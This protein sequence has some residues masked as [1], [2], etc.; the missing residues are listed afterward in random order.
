[1]RTVDRNSQHE[2]IDSEGTWAI[3]YG[4]MVTLLL[5][6]FIL[7]FTV[8]QKK[9]RQKSIQEAIY[10]V[11]LQPNSALASEGTKSQV[12]LGTSGENGIDADIIKELS[13]K[14][15][16]VGNKILIEFP[17]V[18]FFDSGKTELTIK[19][20]A[21]LK[22]FVEKYLPYT[23]SNT[24]SIRAFTDERKVLRAPN[25]KFE[26]NLELSTLRALSTMRKLQAYGLPLAKMR[27]GGFGELRL[28]AS[29]LEKP[30][31]SVAIINTKSENQVTNQVTKKNFEMARK[32]IL[33]IE[34][35]GE[36]DL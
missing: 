19:G 30:V 21:A 2:D 8:D 20:K 34:P 1:M 15:H 16:Q 6:F 4:D 7:F 26:D 33:V 22:L 3:S 32:V 12:S 5:C 11:F 9:D 10:Q 31:E 23:G 17:Q 14:A 29:V 13:G 18:S 35:G 25:R 24:L 27:V 36:M 28:V